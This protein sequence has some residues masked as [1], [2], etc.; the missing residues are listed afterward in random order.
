MN[1]S[2][3]NKFYMAQNSQSRPGA[4]TQRDCA[5]RQISTAHSTSLPIVKKLDHSPFLR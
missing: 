2:G 5:H 3:K 1:F 4:A